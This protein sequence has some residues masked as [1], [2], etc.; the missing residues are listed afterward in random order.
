MRRRNKV[1]LQH[2]I[3]SFAPRMDGHLSFARNNRKFKGKRKRVREF[4]IIRARSIF[5]NGKLV[6][7]PEKKIHHPLRRIYS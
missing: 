3:S 2:F 5:V 7:L 6:H 1:E 4:Q